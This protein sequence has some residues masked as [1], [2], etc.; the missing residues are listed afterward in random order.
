MDK[1]IFLDRDG[2][3]NEEVNYLHRKEDLV[4]LPGVPEA[5]RAFREAGY[6]LVVVTNQAGVARGY[7]E[8]KDVKL[9]HEYMNGLLRPQGAGIDHFFYC[10]HHPEH[11]IGVYKTAC[12][13]RKPE[14]GMFE[15]AEQF[16]EI[17]KEHS[18]M[19]G[20][21]LIDIQ[22][23]KNYHLHTAL[24]GTGYGAKVHEEAMAKRTGLP[25]QETALPY[26]LY[27]DHLDRLAE[28]ILNA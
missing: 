25:G 24:V 21:K 12:R 22:A 14:T 9:L 16:Y 27:A 19:I 7:Y 18:W 4:I 28:K 6:K 8:E 23:G 17:D 5:L 26:E 13:C 11:G 1:V 2:T 20:D 10:P 15:M 3:L